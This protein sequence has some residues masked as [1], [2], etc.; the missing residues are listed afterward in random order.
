MVDHV[1]ATLVLACPDRDHAA[2]RYGQMLRMLSKKLEQ[3]DAS[4]SRIIFRSV[5]ALINI[6]CAFSL[7]LTR[8]SS[9]S[10]DALRNIMEFRHAPTACYFIESVPDDTYCIRPR[11]AK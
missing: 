8:T 3:L 11:T 4:V 6:G 5:Q 1:C 7:P 9:C 2:S 10:R